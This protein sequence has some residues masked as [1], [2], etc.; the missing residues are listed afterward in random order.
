[1]R[2]LIPAVVLLL[3]SSC[4]KTKTFDLAIQNA[5]V[6][7]AVNGTVSAEKTILVNA[8][9]I[10]AILDSGETF[11]ALK[12]I[13][14]AGKL[15]TPGFIDTHTHLGCVFGDYVNA[16]EYLVKDSVAIYRQRLADTYL[17]Y[18]VTVI[19]DVGQ[20]EKWIPVS[21]GWQKDP[22]PYFPDIFICGSAIISDEERTPYISHVEVKSPEDARKKVDE[23]DSL[24]IKY[25]KLYWRLREPELKAVVE[26]GNKKG[27][28]ICGHIDN[29]IMKIG[30]VLDLGVTIFEHCH[31]ITNSV[32]DRAADEDSVWQIMHQYYPGIDSYIPYELE[33]IRYTQD[34]PDLKLKRDSLVGKMIAAHASISTTIHLFGSLCGRTYFNSYLIGKQGIDDPFLTQEQ[35]KRL[36]TAFDIFMA[37]IK[38]AHDKGLQIRIGTDCTDGGK[39]LLSELLLLHEAGISV[40][41]VLKIATINGAI[42]MGIDNKYGS[43]A[44]GKKADLVIFDQN[45]FNE[46]KNFLS[47][48]TVVKDGT[49]YANGI[50]YGN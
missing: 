40:S 19:K 17:R 2:A 11:A 27:M 3:L 42:S 20:P 32:Y 26:E 35:L 8:D 28:N 31:T 9:T 47:G 13:N 33:V 1:M 7:D 44:V 39:A 18:G 21:L 22:S 45:P 43:I 10:A 24:G 6:F 36:N 48:K 50:H 14:A 12:T 37:Y 41:E 5:T 25:L 49:V 16:P 29:G 4:G 38:E 34:H 30:Q 46:Y 23:Y 15:V